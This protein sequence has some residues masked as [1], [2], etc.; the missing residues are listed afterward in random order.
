MPLFVTLE[1]TLTKGERTLADSGRAESVMQ[2]RRDFQD[3]MESDLRQLVEEMTGQRVLA[4]LSAN[5]VAPDVALE[6]FALAP[7]GA[8]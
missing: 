8:G 4:F 3:A 5:H 7:A 1:D 6:A 2:T